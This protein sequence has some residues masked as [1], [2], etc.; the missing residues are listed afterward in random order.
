MYNGT[1]AHRL[2][3]IKI[4]LKCRTKEEAIKGGGAGGQDSPASSLRVATSSADDKLSPTTTEPLSPL[5]PTDCMGP[6]GLP[7]HQAPR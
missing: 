6:D 7:F 2:L 4:T 5:P 3:A 1:W